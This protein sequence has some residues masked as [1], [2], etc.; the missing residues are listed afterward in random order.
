MIDPIAYLKQIEHYN[1][2]INNKLEELAMLW[3]MVTKI[4]STIK[5]DAVS[6]GGG[7]HDKIGEAVSKIVMLEEKINADIDRY[8]DSKES[9]YA[10]LEKLQN[11]DHITVIYKKYFKGETWPQIANDMNMTE[12]NAQI[13]HGRALQAF[14]AILNGKKDK[15]F[16]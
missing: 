14:S 1:T 4:T 6:F 7:N 8:I 10:Q 11:P 3:A 15:N 13:I 12:R 9:I 5:E 16:R 2:H